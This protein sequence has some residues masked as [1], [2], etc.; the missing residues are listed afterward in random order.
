MTKIYSV[1]FLTYDKTDVFFV[2]NIQTKIFL[3]HGKLYKNIKK[4]PLL[5]KSSLEQRPLLF[6]FFSL[7]KVRLLSLKLLH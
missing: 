7:E 6:C 4:R 5:S 1:S 3:L 2:K